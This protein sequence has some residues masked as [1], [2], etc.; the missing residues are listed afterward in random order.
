MKKIIV[1][2]LTIMMCFSLG[3]CGESEEAKAVKTAEMARQVSEAMQELDISITKL[4]SL[5]ITSSQYMIDKCTDLLKEALNIMESH[6]V[7]P[8]DEDY[9][10]ESERFIEKVDAFNDKVDRLF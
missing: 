8:D 3:A 1:L 4:S 7:Y 6:D 10:K 5:P 2:L 9:I